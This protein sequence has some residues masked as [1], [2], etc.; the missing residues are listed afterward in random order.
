MGIGDWGL[1][2][3]DWGINWLKKYTNLYIDITGEPRPFYNNYRQNSQGSYDSGV[4]PDITGRFIAESICGKTED[5]RYVISGQLCNR[6]TKPVAPNLPVSF[7]YYDESA[8]GHRGERIC[9]AYTGSTLHI[10]ECGQIGCIITEETLDTLPGKKVLMI[11]NLDEYGN[12]STVE[13]NTEN[14]TASI[15]IDKCDDDIAII[16]H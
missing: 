1:G 15:V 16:H 4:V 8:T 5:D 7:F 12:A 14:N 3:G 10:G 11:T 9:T 2:I 13:C 6:G